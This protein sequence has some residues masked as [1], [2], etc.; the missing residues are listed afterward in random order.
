[1]R[2]PVIEY[3]RTFLTRWGRYPTEAEILRHFGFGQRAQLPV[4]R[5]LCAN[6]VLTIEEVL[7]REVPDRRIVA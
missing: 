5:R 3:Q 6:P 1:M 2:H 7:R 4:L